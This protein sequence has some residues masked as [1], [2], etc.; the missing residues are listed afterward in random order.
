DGLAALL[1]QVDKYG[2]Y[3][4]LTQNFSPRQPIFSHMTAIAAL[5]SKLNLSWEAGGFCQVNLEQNSRLINLVLAMAASGPH[6]TILDL[7]CG[8]GNFSLPLALLAEKVLGIDSQN[9]AIRS[10]RQNVAQAGN[11]NCL[12][13]KRPVPDAVRS[14][15]AAGETFE[16]I[17]LDP[18][19]QGAPEVM[20][21]LPK[22]EA[23]QIIY[24][25]CDPAT[26]ARDLVTL[27]GAGYQVSRLIPV[28]MFPQTHHLESVVLLKRA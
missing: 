15:V 20:S 10:A 16:T 13:E 5:K 22:L 23:Q 14:L 4:P 21:L 28:D 19:R 7:F 8:Y 26:L 24:I 27:H 25:S 17:V 1:M 3:D 6:R 9:A 18:P 12:F 2:L 11:R